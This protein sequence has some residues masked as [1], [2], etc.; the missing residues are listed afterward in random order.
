MPRDK[1][2]TN[3]SNPHVR[4][5]EFYAGILAHPEVS[6]ETKNTIASVVT[7]MANK[8]EVGITDPDFLPRAFPLIMEKLSPV[9]VSGIQRTLLTMFERGGDAE[10]IESVRAQ[11]FD[12]KREPK[13]AVTE[14]P[15]TT[16]ARQIVAFLNSSRR[17]DF[18]TDALVDAIQD[19]AMRLDLAPPN[20]QETEE[21]QIKSIA[22]ILAAAPTAFSLR[23]K[24][25]LAD[26]IAAVMQDEETP[27]DLFNAMQDALGQMAAKNAV[28]NSP[29]VIRVALAENKPAE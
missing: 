21:G 10:A 13:N 28:G 8:A 19:A 14:S 2:T 12:A 6:E 4:D 7:E 26:H 20:F 15:A 9:Y 18:I 25:D 23:G 1:D 16:E 11:V 22:A 17:S 27:T 3:K 29:A 5:G 24:P